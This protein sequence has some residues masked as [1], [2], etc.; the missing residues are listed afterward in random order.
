LEFLLYPQ[1]IPRLCNARR[2]GP[3]VRITGPSAWPWIAHSVSRLPPATLSPYSD[4]LSLRLRVSPHSDSLSLRLRVSPRLASPQRSN[5]P[6]HSSIGTPS[7]RRSGT[8]TACRHVV[9]GTISLPSRGAFHLSLTVLVHYRSTG[10]FSLG[11]WSPQLPTRLHVSGRTQG[12][13]PQSQIVR[14]R[15]CHPLWPPVPG[16]FDWTCDFSLRDRS[17][18]PVSATLQH[19]PSIGLPPVKLGGFGLL[20][21]RSPLLGE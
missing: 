12:C 16:T 3:P 10:V 5:S 9:S 1:L 11:E 17:G 6:A 21:V 4:S 18:R 14:L 13:A 19:P 8:L 2:F 20:P 15:G 7:S